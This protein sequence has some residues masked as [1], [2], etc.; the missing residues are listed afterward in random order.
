MVMA[1][2]G[3][4]PWQQG[5]TALPAQTPNTGQ[6]T[7]KIPAERW[8]ELEREVDTARE[9]EQSKGAES[10]G[11]ST[12]DSLAGRSTSQQQAQEGSAPPPQPEFTDLVTW[13]DATRAELL[14]AQQRAQRTAD[15]FKRGAERARPGTGG[16]WI[17]KTLSAQKDVDG[18][19]RLLQEYPEIRERAREAS[20]KGPSE[21]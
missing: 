14:R 13:L 16:G 19:E 11:S 20:Q 2:M 18:F 3:W 5:A 21:D 7:K 6:R 17:E 12:P 10:A 8:Q 9:P 15:Y 4:V 1:R